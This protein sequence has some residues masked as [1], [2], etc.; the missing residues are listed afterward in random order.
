MG[1]LGSLAV[2]FST[3]F[4][5]VFS[6]IGDLSPTF[7]AERSRPSIGICIVFLTPNP[8]T[9]AFN[10]IFS[11]SYALSQLVSHNYS[12]SLTYT[13]SLSARRYRKGYISSV[14]NNKRRVR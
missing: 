2:L 6:P 4:R 7:S 12:L 5:A 1:G 8:N 9:H 13:Y 3:C 10:L 14:V 11:Y